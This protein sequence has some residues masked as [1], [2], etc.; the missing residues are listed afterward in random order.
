MLKLI[1][2]GPW[3][4]LNAMAGFPGGCWMMAVAR[5]SSKFSRRLLVHRSSVL[6][7]KPPRNTQFSPEVVGH[8]HTGWK[9]LASR[10]ASGP[11]GAAGLPAG[12]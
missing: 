8:P 6:T 11:W 10:L 5:Y 4:S 9:L 3:D 12:R 2:G 7:A 1:G